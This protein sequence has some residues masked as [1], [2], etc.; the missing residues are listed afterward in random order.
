MLYR[1]LCTFTFPIVTWIFCRQIARSQDTWR[2]ISML[3]FVSLPL[4]HCN[5]CHGCRS[6]CLFCHCA[7]T[8]ISISQS[9][10]HH[11]FIIKRYYRYYHFGL[12]VGKIQISWL[13]D[14]KCWHLKYE[15]KLVILLNITTNVFSPV[16]SLPKVNNSTT[17]QCTDTNMTAIKWPRVVNGI[18]ILLRWSGE[19]RL[20]DAIARNFEF[21]VQS[22]GYEDI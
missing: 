17:M 19:S 22:F 6:G 21:G 18:F 20:T 1:L 14:T 15:S 10:T 8:T 12:D 4:C 5:I 13:I 16:C 2:K 3:V 7:I 11:I 9:Q